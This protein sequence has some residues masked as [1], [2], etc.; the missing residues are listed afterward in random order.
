MRLAALVAALVPA[1]ARI[2]RRTRIGPLGGSVA[3]R[4][5][6]AKVISERRGV[7]DA[8]QTD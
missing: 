7:G 6:G 4:C 3:S 5:V 8:S 2:R 1:P